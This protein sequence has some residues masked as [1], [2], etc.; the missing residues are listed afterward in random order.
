MK[1]IMMSYDPLLS[2]N[3]RNITCSIIYIYILEI[4]IKN[5]KITHVFISRDDLIA[6]PTLPK[7]KRPACFLQ[8]YVAC[9]I[10]LWFVYFYYQSVLLVN[11][12]NL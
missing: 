2:N 5:V 10:L 11:Y 7:S 9:Y 6:K 4:D 1:I 12:L 8:K 3:L